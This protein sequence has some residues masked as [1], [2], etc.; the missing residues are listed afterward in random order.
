[1]LSALLELLRTFIY[2]VADRKYLLFTA[3]SNLIANL[4]DF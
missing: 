3:E 1:M 2:F 4:K